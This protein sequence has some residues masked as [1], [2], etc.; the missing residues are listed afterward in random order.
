MEKIINE[1][2]NNNYFKPNDSVVVGVSGGPDSM[3]LLTILQKVSKKINLNIIVAHVNHNTGRK[4]Q[5]L[6]Q[7]FVTE[8]CD[9]FNLKLEVLTIK[10]YNDDNF[11]N[12]ARKIRYNFFNDLSIKY[13][14]KYILTAHHADD[15]METI[16]MRIV[17][18]S[19]IKGYSGFS[20]ETYYENYTILRP[21]IST[22]KDEI[23][24]YLKENNIDYRI[25]DSNLKDTY[26]RNRFRKYIIPALK[27]EDVNVAN[28]FYKFSKTLIECN[29]YIDSY[30]KK[31]Y[32]TICPNDIVN[33]DL[34]LKESHI[35]QTKI[36]STMLLEKYQDDLMLIT[37]KHTDLILNLIESGKSNSTIYLPNNIKA[38]KSYNK[39]YFSK[40]EDEDNSYEIQIDDHVI[41]PNGHVINKIDFTLSN[42]N[43]ICRISYDK[44]KMPLYVRNKKAG[45]KIIVKGMKEAK[46]IK[47]IFINEKVELKK[48]ST[49]PIVC[50]SENNIVWIPGL[51][52]SHFCANKDEK[53]DIILKYN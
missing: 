6:D 20:K 19:T 17:R 47:D 34:F 15:L 40:Y 23:Y 51:K 29:N 32:N 22:T 8:Y 1:L 41:L 30:I 24:K 38:V 21:L 45:D 31:I 37:D 14:A 5:I 18:G 12:E 10:D 49:W 13:N 36:I 35:I 9:K 46:K 43:N 26:T 28:K 52:K 16:L 42:D 7:K 25:D 50:D 4:G 11:H 2:I 3:C 44:V 48:R 27:N 33:I 53:C 39:F